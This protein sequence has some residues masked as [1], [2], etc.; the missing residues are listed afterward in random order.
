[1]M[2]S[3]I[4][5]LYLLQGATAL[6][7]A[8]ASIAIVR[9]QKKLRDSAAFWASPAGDVVREEASAAESA[10]VSVADQLAELR[11]LLASL[12]TRERNAV[13]VTAGESRIE[14]AVMLARQGA[15][16]NELAKHCGLN[17]G[18]A[19]LLIRLHGPRSVLTDAA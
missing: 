14:N 6:L 13:S 7:A 18:E 17:N 3:E 15:S 10:E 5:L 8:A 4:Q 12:A 9:F 1:M 19:Q 16:L 2:L 11:L